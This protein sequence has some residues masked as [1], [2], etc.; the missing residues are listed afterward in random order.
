MVIAL[1]YNIAQ[2]PNKIAQP[3]A[4]WKVKG[5]IDSQ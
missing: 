4:V 5:K 3:S 2:R 1:I